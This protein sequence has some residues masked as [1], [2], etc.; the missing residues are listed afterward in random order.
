MHLVFTPPA[1]VRLDIGAALAG[2]GARAGDRSKGVTTR[3]L[4]AIT[5]ETEK[6]SH[7]F[8]AQAQ[9]FGIEDP[10]IANLDFR[11]TH[12]AFL[13]DL[14]MISGQQANIDLDPSVPRVNIATDSGGVQARR[15]VEALIAAEK[16]GE[17][18]RIAATPLS[19]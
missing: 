9:D 10:S 15:V 13:E 12:G 17:P 18:K 4:N 3:N 1:F 19:P 16:A 5:P 8:W 14:K 6:T 2:T 11:M 7:Y